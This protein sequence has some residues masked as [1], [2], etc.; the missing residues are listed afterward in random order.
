MQDIVI[1]NERLKVCVCCRWLAGCQQ[2]TQFHEHHCAAGVGTHS[3]DEE[4]TP[5]RSSS[6]I[7][8]M[9]AATAY[10]GYVGWQNKKE[11]AS[12]TG[13]LRSFARKNICAIVLLNVPGPQKQVRLK[14]ST[15]PGRRLLVFCVGRCHDERDGV[16]ACCVGEHGRP[17]PLGVSLA[18]HRTTYNILCPV[19]CAAAILFCHLP[20]TLR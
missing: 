18:H 3:V 15:M 16:V 8:Y 10:L 9:S 19:T 7:V 6:G 5:E 11:R 1:D 17:D 2:Q 12:D 20:S 14:T 13:S 4:S